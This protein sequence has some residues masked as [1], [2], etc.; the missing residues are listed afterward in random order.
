VLACR[1]LPHSAGEHRQLR[2]FTRGGS[3]V[4]RRT[5]LRR[6][7]S[8]APLDAQ[9]PTS[10]DMDR[11]DVAL[12]ENAIN[13]RATVNCQSRYDVSHPHCRTSLLLGVR[14]PRSVLQVALVPLEDC[15][16]SKSLPPK[17][18]SLPPRAPGVHT[19]LARASLAHVEFA[20]VPSVNLS[21][22]RKRQLRLKL[23]AYS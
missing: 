9:F 18:C 16:D 14:A 6:K 4:S 12:C 8:I 1:M 2:S 20:R 11:T 3:V 22:C 5:G 23:F 15:V 17:V 10:S 13:R 19:E 21:R 7:T